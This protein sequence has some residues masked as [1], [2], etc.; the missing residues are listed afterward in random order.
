MRIV[1]P[2]SNEWG[3]ASSWG[4]WA[5]LFA[6]LSAVSPAAAQPTTIPDPPARSSPPAVGTSGFRSSANLGG[7]Y[8]WLGPV[9]AASR[10]EGGWD[11]TFG[12]D[13]SVVRVDESAF[14]GVLGA[15][16]GASM[17]S[18]REGGRIWLDTLAGT[19]IAGR[20]YGLS[21]GG[22][23]ELAELEHPRFGGSVGA[24]A[25]FGVAPF[26]RVGVVEELGTFAEIGLHLA[27]PVWSSR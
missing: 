25:F 26:V 4:C 6:A 1:V 27:L 15:T 8:V 22:I 5:A 17:W 16:A 14:A 11:S 13:L 18:E 24:W 23:V 2:R 19:R 21:L 20:M 10:A 3:L 9:G 12:G 7:I